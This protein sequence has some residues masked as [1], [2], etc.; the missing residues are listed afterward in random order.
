M[1]PL[2]QI[3]AGTLRALQG[4]M[5]NASAAAD[6]AVAAPSTHPPDLGAPRVVVVPLGGARDGT[7]P[8]AVLTARRH[9]GGNG[10]GVADGAESWAR[11]AAGMAAAAVELS[12]PSGALTPSTARPTS[13]EPPDSFAGGLL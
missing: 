3:C 6:L 12:G 9:S 2:N 5:D 8:P 7:K 11:G 4:M 13:P 1:L 10:R